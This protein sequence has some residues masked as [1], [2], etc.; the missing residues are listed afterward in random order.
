MRIGYIDSFKGLGILGVVMI[1]LPG[2]GIPSSF[3]QLMVYW[4][5]FS[6]F[7]ISGWLYRLNGKKRTPQEHFKIR[8]NKFGKVY[9]IFTLIFIA[10]DAMLVAVGW[11][12]P[13]IIA[14]DI[15]KSI[16]LT[17]IGTLWFLPVLLFGETLFVM[18]LDFKRYRKT[19]ITAVTVIAVFIVFGNTTWCRDLYYSGMIG[20]ALCMPVDTVGQIGECCLCVSLGYLCA[21]YLFPYMIRIENKLTK[22]VLSI[23]AGFLL[24]LSIIVSPCLYEWHL[25]L[26]RLLLIVPVS[27][28]IIMIFMMFENNPVSR[29]LGFWGRNSLML[30]CTHYSLTLVVIEIADTMINGEATQSRLGTW[31]YFTLCILLTY[32]LISSRIVEKYLRLK[33][34]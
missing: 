26:V 33:I 9:L 31:I 8:F 21:K 3:M 15:Y 6:F 5:V 13:A 16:V 22:A 11:H 28:S 10:F 1:H 7:F 4:A 23:A 24:I 32:C 30:M 25:L 34:S 14:K 2:E 27:V 18:C 19:V 29:F 12:D 20:Q 17:G